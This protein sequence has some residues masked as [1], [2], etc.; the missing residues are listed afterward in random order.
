MRIRGDSA[1]MHG[2]CPVFPE[3]EIQHLDKYGKCHGKIDVPLGDVQIEPFTN[4]GQSDQKQKAQCEDFHRRMP[5]YEAADRAG[6]R[7]HDDDGNDDGRNHHRE[8]IDQSYGR[9]HRVEGENDIQ[10]DN[11]NNDGGEGTGFIKVQVSVR[12]LAFM[13][14]SYLFFVGWVKR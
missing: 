14:N 2:L 8:L 5:F 10:D 12:L 3:P 6:H 4:E 13:V 1:Q 9:N 7:H 11:L